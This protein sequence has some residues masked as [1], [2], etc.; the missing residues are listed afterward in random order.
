MF[1]NFYQHA[2]YTVVYLSRQAFLNPP[3]LATM[4]RTLKSSIPCED[5]RLL[6]YCIEVVTVRPDLYR[7]WLVE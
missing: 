1:F 6:Q 5:T 7:A 3:F 4:I 2:T